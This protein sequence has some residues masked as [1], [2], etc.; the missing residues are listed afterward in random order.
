VFFLIF[1]K[2]PVK[3]KSFPQEKKKTNKQTPSTQNLNS[4][5][6]KIGPFSDHQNLIFHLILPAGPSDGA[7]AQSPASDEAERLPTTNSAQQRGYGLFRCSSRAAH[8]LCSSVIA[9]FLR[10]AAAPSLS[11]YCC[12][13][14]AI[15]RIL[16]QLYLQLAGVAAVSY[17]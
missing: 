12:Y 11:L 15:L 1:P 16:F 8:K 7:S 17:K 6:V 4:P 14:L 10:A 13:Y 5:L 9:T 2:C 3:P